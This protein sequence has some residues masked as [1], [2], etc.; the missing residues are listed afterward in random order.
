MGAN[1]A[2][3]AS[4]VQASSGLLAAQHA[5]A[6][7]QAQIDECN[8]AC[9]HIVGNACGLLLSPDV[10][11]AISGATA[12]AAIYDTFRDSNVEFNYNL[13]EAVKLTLCG[14]LGANCGRNL[15][16]ELVD[17]LCMTKNER[18]IRR[19]NAAKDEAAALGHF[20]TP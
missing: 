5:Q 12:A 16:K 2:I 20:M 11:G 14:C 8:E 3:D 7:E 10:I 18:L 9:N 4:E 17:K 6:D 15:Y 19:L 13:E 1:R